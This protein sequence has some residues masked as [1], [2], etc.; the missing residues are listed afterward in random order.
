MKLVTPLVLVVAA[1]CVVA[2]VFVVFGLGWALI[3]FGALVIAERLVPS[4]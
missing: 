2:G 1:L 3:V 4:R